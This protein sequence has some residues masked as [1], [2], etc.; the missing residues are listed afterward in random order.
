MKSLKQVLAERVS[1][2]AFK[3]MPC[4]TVPTF[5]TIPLPT[6]SFV[7][8]SERPTKRPWHSNQ[9]NTTGCARPRAC[10]P[11]RDTS[12]QSGCRCQTPRC[13]ALERLRKQMCPSP[14]LFREQ[15]KSRPSIFANTG[16][17]PAWRSPAE[18]AP[19]RAEAS[20]HDQARADAGMCCP[21]F[22]FLFL[23]C[24]SVL[25]PACS[26]LSTIFTPPPFFFSSDGRSMLLVG[27][28]SA[29]IRPS[30]RSGL[31]Y[32]MTL[33]FHCPFY[34]CENRAHSCSHYAPKAMTNDAVMKEFSIVAEL[35]LS[36]EHPTSINPRAKV[37]E[38]WMATAG[39]RD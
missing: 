15:L 12:S 16:G 29:R 10:R 11:Y 2:V 3:L 5:L 9:T 6:T 17:W 35:L 4:Y 18:P 19:S 30:S 26:C 8:N 27:P 25:A 13:V 34:I 37:N 38:C 31:R 32:A 1:G 36:G 20:A 14:R 39:F 24:I 22:F 21:V 28:R 23:P 7:C 33:C